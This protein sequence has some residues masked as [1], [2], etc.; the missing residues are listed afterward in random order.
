MPDRK[1]ATVAL[2]L[3]GCDLGTSGVSVFA[4]AVLPRL[5]AHLAARG[6]QSFVLGTAQEREAA[7]MQDAPGP[8][9]PAILDAPAASAGFTL[10]GAPV[11][12][13]MLGAR[14]LYLP[15]ANRRIVGLP[16]VPVV[17]TVHDLAQFHVEAKYG[18]LRQVYVQ[19]V[20]TP[21]LSRLRVLTAVSQTTATE[22]E[23]FAHVPQARIR[24]VPNGVT[25]GKRPGNAARADSKYLLYP[26]RLEH[27]GKNHLRV[28]DGFARARL[29]ATHRLVFTGADWGAEGL[30][31]ERIAALGLEGRVELAGFLSRDELTAR[32]AC[33]D[34]VLAA[35]LFE[36]FG[37]PAAEALA[38]GRPIAGSST[39]SLPEVM[40]GL[41]ALFDPLDVDS[42]AAALDRV[43][44]DQALRARCRDEGPAHAAKFSW[45]KTAA[46]IGDALCEVLDAAA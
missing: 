16:A 37:L 39:G 7:K 40:G 22:V 17:G 41:G 18:R 26:A 10:A 23:R 5:R 38:L 28:L 24:V 4:E 3:A 13:R 19:R 6:V 36:G 20:L 31:R 12:A 33:A 2:S 45:D 35:G 46:G 21:L 42:I 30:I 34:A 29:R 25:L 27:P 11:V 9:L 15:C 1:P 32:M 14:L 44:E 43:A 8:V